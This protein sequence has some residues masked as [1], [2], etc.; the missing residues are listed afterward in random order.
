MARVQTTATPGNLPCA[1][2]L[3]TRLEILIAPTASEKIRK[4][5]AF[6]DS[7]VRG[8]KAVYGMN[9]GFGKF[10]EVAIPNDKLDELQKNLILSHA[11]GTGP[12]SRATVFCM[13]ILRLN[14][15]CRGNSGVRPETI[16][17]IV[18]L[19]QAGC[20]AEVPSV[21]ASEASGDLAPS[22][23]ATLALI[24]EGKVSLPMMAASKKCPH[25]KR[26]VAWDLNP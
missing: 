1:P 16:A 15:L 13:W 24:G 14:T 3:P 8:S 26:S 6:V 10:A 25:A 5:A 2:A 12:V 17:F 20:L 22:A 7:V 9:T 19:L 11:C 23:H 18:K 21:A 4:A